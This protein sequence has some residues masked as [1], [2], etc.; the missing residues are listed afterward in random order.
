MK[1]HGKLPPVV[2]LVAAAAAFWLA[3]AAGPGAVGSTPRAGHVI[4]ISVDGL[5]GDL[6][7]A[8][9][10]S[11]PASYPNFNRLRKEGAST[12]EARCDVDYSETLPN[13]VSMVLGRPV[14]AGGC[15]RHGAPRN[16]REHAGSR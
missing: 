4:L 9:M 10:D 14:A 15:P 11:T 1:Y 2:A 13:H 8:L 7:Q 12:F 5:R 3:F 6:L 16:Y